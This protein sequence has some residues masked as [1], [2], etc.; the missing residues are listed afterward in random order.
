MNI[1]GEEVA[2]KRKVYEKSR[3]VAWSNEDSILKLSTT[4][5]KENS[6]MKDRFGID[7]IE[8]SLF[9]FLIF[10]VSLLSLALL[11]RVKMPKSSVFLSG[12]TNNFGITRPN[13]PNKTFYFFGLF[14]FY[15]CVYFF[16]A[17][18]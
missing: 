16:I 13:S 14:L 10:R 1:N 18:P 8:V 2:N 7:A 15:S 11:S 3:L 4:I 5:M 6:E 12:S 9:C 17:L